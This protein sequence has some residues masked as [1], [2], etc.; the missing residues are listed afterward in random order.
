[1]PQTDGLCNDYALLLGTKRINQADIGGILGMGETYMAPLPL[2]A[3]SNCMLHTFGL[4]NCRYITIQRGHSTV[5]EK[6]QKNTK[7]WPCEHYQTL[8][9]LL[10]KKYP[11]Y[12]LVQLGINRPGFDV[13][14]KGI[15]VNLRGKTSIVQLCSVLKY[16]SLHIDCEGG[17]VHLRHALHGGPSVVLFGPT[18]PKF[19]GYTE[20]LNLRTQACAQPCEWV[21]D[22]WLTRCARR[23]DKHCCMRGLTPKWVLEQIEKEKLL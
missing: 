6:S 12:K 2:P 1:M 21:T 9:E 13:D 4:A 19:Y 23:G 20:N 5:E 14:F 16:A 22:D 7:L 10:K 15:D 8:I 3:D 18:S 17:L 11:S